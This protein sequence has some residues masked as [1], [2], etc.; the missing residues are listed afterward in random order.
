[1]AKGKAGRPSRA[2]SL[3]GTDRREL[4]RLQRRANRARQFPVNTCPASRHLHSMADTLGRGREYLMFREEPQHCATSI[5]AVIAAL[6]E[7]RT[8]LARLKAKA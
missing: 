2:V 8:A 5:L 1:M 7:A 3:G 6:W 4:R